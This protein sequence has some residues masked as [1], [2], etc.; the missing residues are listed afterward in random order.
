MIRVSSFLQRHPESGLLY[1]RLSIPP[2]YRAAIGRT[3]IK[4]SLGTHD[5]RLALPAAMQL[6]CE[7]QQLFNQ[8]DTGATMPTKRRKKDT[9]SSTMSKITLAEIVLPGGGKA[10]NVVIDTGDDVRDAEV[11]VKLLGGLPAAPVAVPASM[12]DSVKLAVAAK[13][14]R[15]EK[16][17]EGSWVDSTVAEHEALHNLLI[18]FLGNPDVSTVTHKHAREVKDALL[19]LP[20]NMGKGKYAGKG[21]RQLLKMNVPSSARQSIRTVNEKIT[22][23]GSFFQWCVRHG[24]APLN[25][26]EGLKMKVSVRASEE[27]AAFDADDLQAIFAPLDAMRK[28]FML[29]CPWLALFT[30]GR[31]TEIAQ[32]RVVDVFEVDGVPAIRI[33]DDA[34]RLKTLA[35]RREVPLHPALVQKGF[36][37]YVAGIKAAGHDKL[38]PDV[39]GNL[40]GPGDR[41]SRWFAVFRKN[42]KIGSMKKG[43]GKPVKCFH[44]FRHN[45]ADGLKQAGVDGLIIAQ[46]MGH[47][48]ASM[49]TGRYGK[50][51]PLTTLNEAVCRLAFPV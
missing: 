9:S 18:Q 49:S 38:F 19:A 8:L 20:A 42:L 22:R 15:A 30:G 14:Y 13:K 33:D 50:S 16:V 21:V 10:R 25:P 44:S 35:S 28:P 48:D 1:F 34:G 47:V 23:A 5:K 51:Y 43:D 27:R 31:A 36:L 7:V 12:G 32:L 41:L 26:F 40:N 46:L 29:W 24:Y 17:A 37:E 39:W 4:R 2:R 6:Y 11:A 45:F 3:E